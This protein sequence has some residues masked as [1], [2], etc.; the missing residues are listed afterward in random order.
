MI[1][2]DDLEAALRPLLTQIGAS[3]PADFGKA[4]GVCSKAMAGKAE[5]KVVADMVKRLL[6]G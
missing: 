5:G 6:Q 3:G 2:G 1:E 4:M